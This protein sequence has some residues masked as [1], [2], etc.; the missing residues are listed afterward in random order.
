MS[1]LIEI[2]ADYSK[3]A[4]GG[5]TRKYT[6]EPYFEHC[7][8][9]AETVRNYGGSPVMIA[10]AYL[11][12]VLEDT[13]LNVNGFGDR[14]RALVEELTD[15]ETGNRAE[16]KFKAAMRLS[17][18]SPEAQT[19]KLADFLSNTPSICEHDPEFAAIYLAEVCFTLA[20][21]NKGNAELRHAIYNTLLRH[22]EGIRNFKSY[23]THYDKLAA[24]L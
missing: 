8:E 1:R 17:K 13:P 16:R 21:L 2:A 9:V 15:T 6:G 20:Y 18:A 19:I 3:M 22:V 11:H 12:D 7:K 4:H 5:Q 23:S 14:V 10:A 24:Q